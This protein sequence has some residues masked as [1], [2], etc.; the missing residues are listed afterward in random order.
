[1]ITAA[2]FLIAL[3]LTGVPPAEVE[4]VARVVYTEARGEPI[5]ARIGVANVVM[6]RVHATHQS[7]CEVVHEPGQFQGLLHP[8]ITEEPA[9]RDA[10]EIGTFVYAGLISDHTA[11]AYFFVEKPALGKMHR[12]VTRIYGHFVFLIQERIPDYAEGQS[13]QPITGQH[14][15]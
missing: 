11:G 7:A 14:A 9:W 5:M 8:E 12:V 3:G 1:M 10:L 13:D 6:N 15:G 4:C 2:A